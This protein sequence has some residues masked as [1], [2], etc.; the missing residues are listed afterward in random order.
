MLL[1]NDIN[2]YDWSVKVGQNRA[3]DEMINLL[4]LSHF[5]YCKSR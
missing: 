1:F 2:D 5:H 4:W 3:L